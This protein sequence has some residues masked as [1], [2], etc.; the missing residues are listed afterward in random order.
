MSVLTS[1]FEASLVPRPLDLTPVAT[2]ASVTSP[3]AED[4]SGVETDGVDEVRTATGEIFASDSAHGEDQ[5]NRTAPFDEAG[6]S[7]QGHRDSTTLGSFAGRWSG[8][9]AGS[10]TPTDAKPDTQAP[11][12][13]P[14]HRESGIL[15]L[16]PGE[17]RVLSA[18][19]PLERS[20]EVPEGTVQSISEGDE[21]TTQVSPSTRLG[22]TG[23]AS[24]DDLDAACNEIGST[25]SPDIAQD[26]GTLQRGGES[27]PA[28][29][30]SM[31]KTHAAEPFD[32][33]DRDAGLSPT[34]DSDERT[35]QPTI[36]SETKAGRSELRR[37]SIGVAETTN[38]GDDPGISV[39]KTRPLPEHPTDWPFPSDKD[40]VPATVYR[41]TETMNYTGPH[42]EVRS[43]RQLASLESGHRRD[44]SFC[45]IS[46]C[47]DKCCRCD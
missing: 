36:R 21:W 43:H 25:L 13:Q 10:T 22:L 16:S 28:D 37:A 3:L 32:R 20:L 39:A 38:G 1:Y 7:N 11:F 24:G 35:R 5:Q 27:I 18:A 8:D 12:A 9:D 23:I 44:G 26:A 30:G 47:L 45:G 42:V 34:D 19:V 2:R 40:T 29:A 4:R 31:V 6:S 33:Q 46:H 15:G 41:R 14:S 17:R